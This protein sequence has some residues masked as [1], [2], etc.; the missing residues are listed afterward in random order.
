MLHN[1]IT[2]VF[3][4]KCSVCSIRILKKTDCTKSLQQFVQLFVD[5]YNITR[6]SYRGW[7]GGGAPMLIRALKARICVQLEC[8]C[9]PIALYIILRKENTSIPVL[10]NGDTSYET[11]LDK[12]KVLN[13]QYLLKNLALHYL[14][15]V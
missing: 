3:L 4:R 8:I 6:V 7:M 9:I 2:L 5:Y 11:S 15:R 12:A 13:S 14:T 10:V 1:F